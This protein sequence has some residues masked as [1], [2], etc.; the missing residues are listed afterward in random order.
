MPD[1]TPAKPPI[2]M[3]LIRWITRVLGGGIFLLMLAIA[4]G[5]GAPNPWTQPWRVG[6]GLHLMLIIWLGT[7]IGW[8]WEGLGGAMILGGAM[9]F[10]AIGPHRLGLID[11]LWLLAGLGYLGCWMADR[12]RF[13]G[14]H[15]A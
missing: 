15:R 4:V 12:R 3:V 14:L 7:A 9:A 13:A 2:L 10:Y 1:S 8:K 11:A 6:L 5:E